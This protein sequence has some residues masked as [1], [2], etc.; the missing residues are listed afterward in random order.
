MNDHEFMARP[1]PTL[2]RPLLGITVLLVEDSRFASEAVRL[3]GLRSGARIRRADCLASARRHLGAYRP[4]VVIVDLGL[5]DGSGIDLIAELASV[6]ETGCALIATSGDDGAEDA[7]RAAGAQGFL[8]KPVANLG[9][10]QEAIL[11]LLPPE[12]QPKGLRIL[13][14]DTVAPDPL[15]YRDDMAHVADLMDGP[16]PDAQTLGYIAQFLQAVARS[17]DDGP[18]GDAARRLSAA[19]GAPTP[20]LAALRQM[21]ATRMADPAI[22]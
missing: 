11:A 13:S 6:P 8:A 15:A 7:A 18:L 2:A 17:A 9:V 10:F 12:A 21:I 1:Q 19:K 16:A 3:M 14:A 5:P 4:S 22:V 20:D